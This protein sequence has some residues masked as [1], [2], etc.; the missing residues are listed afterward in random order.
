[1][2]T[3]ILGPS[4]LGPEG[5]TVAQAWAK[6]K[7]APQFFI[8]NAKLYWWWGAFIG[9]RPEVAYAQHAKETGYGKFG[10]VVDESFHN[11]AGIKIKAGGDNYDPN[12]HQRFATWD[13]GV[14]AHFNH[15]SAYCMGKGGKTIGTPHERYYVV[16]TTAWAGTIK[17]VEQLSTRWAPSATYGQDL[18]KNQLDPLVKYTLEV[19][20]PQNLELQKAQAEIASLQEQL[21]AAN[22]KLADIKKI[23]G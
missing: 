12:A 21:K 2:G 18:V 7:G 3:P 11:P 20:I 15:L 23:L 6:S 19:T 13:L 1:M 5:W 10:G 14:Q 22:S 17:E 8:D 4:Q 9:I 16:L